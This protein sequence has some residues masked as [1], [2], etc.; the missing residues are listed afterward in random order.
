MNRIA[1]LT[2]LA[3]FALVRVCSPT[4]AQEA[5]VP[6][7]SRMVDF[8]YRNGIT[9]YSGSVVVDIPGFL[10]L[11]CEDLVAVQS[12][13]TN[14]LDVLTATTNVVLLLNRPGRSTNDAPIQIRATGDRAVFAAT[15]NL[16]T[17]TGE[18][19]QMPQVETP[20]FKTRA[21]VIT[22]NLGT[23]RVLGLSNHVTEINPDLFRN[24]GLFQ[25]TN[26]PASK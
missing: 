2:C 21:S 18:A 24:S 1:S 26:R 8:D 5:K 23:G 14:R 11:T 22:Y 9:H 15:N 6:I 4:Q 10:Q 17:L 3:V 19:G 13:G 12:A 25:R 20:Q 16:V 7:R